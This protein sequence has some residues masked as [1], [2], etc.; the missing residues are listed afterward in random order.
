[1]I[2]LK[3]ELKKAGS[4]IQN[5][6]KKFSLDYPEIKYLLVIEGQA[7]KDN[8]PRNYELSYASILVL[9]DHPLG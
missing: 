4:S 6:L 7:S 8:Y 9:V 2:T 1:M 3:N 5:S